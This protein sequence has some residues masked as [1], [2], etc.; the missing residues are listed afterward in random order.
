MRP[1][2][3]DPILLPKEATQQYADLLALR[4]DM[5]AGKR[6]GAKWTGGE[7]ACSPVRMPAWALCGILIVTL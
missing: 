3:P 6:G 1:G 5:A 7:E 4:D 2:L